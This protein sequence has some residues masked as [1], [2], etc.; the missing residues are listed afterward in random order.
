MLNFK[1][2]VHFM[3]QKAYRTNTSS[4][5]QSNNKASRIA[6]RP[7]LR[8]FALSGILMS[9]AYAGGKADD[10]IRT[11]ISSTFDNVNKFECEGGERSAICKIDRYDFQNAD[12][13]A[14]RNYRYTVD[15]KDTR[16]IERAS[17]DIEV[18]SNYDLKIFVP[19][20]FE[21]SDF[22]QLH[23]EKQQI[24]EQ[25]VCAINSDTYKVQFRLRAKTH[26]PAFANVN[27]MSFLQK[28][29]AFMDKAIKEIANTRD[30]KQLKEKMEGF[31]KLLNTI[32]VNIYGVDIAITKPNLPQK[33][34]EYV[35]DDMLDDIDDATEHASSRASQLSRTLYNT[36]VGY[37][38]GN[39]IGYV[40]GN[41]SIDSRTKESL[42]KL[43]TTLR[44]SAMLNSN[45]RTVY[46]TITNRTN[47]GFNL[48]R[49]VDKITQK[50][51]SF[52]QLNR[53][54]VGKTLN[55]FDGEVFNRYRIEVGATRFK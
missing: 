41:D 45:I 23:N 20:H 34:Y 9:S 19:K 15:Y 53:D 48:G 17:G 11:S 38:Y 5:M 21:C 54:Q 32:D 6:V 52:S 40:W 14:L 31:K 55:L 22:T 3:Q 29:T 36:A 42:N 1:G 8:V 43:F 39:A 18:P 30:N 28:S 49:A 46:I 24:N 26:A 33:I 35:F 2:I 13:F 51:A 12:G 16:V 37:I 47:K 44:D 50:T 10:Y 7:L 4:P 25:L 27:A